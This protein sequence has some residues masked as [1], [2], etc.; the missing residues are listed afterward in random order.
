MSLHNRRCNAL[1]P[2]PIQTYGPSF[3][4]IGLPT[5]V[6]SLHVLE[7]NH[8]EEDEQLVQVSSNV[9]VANLLQSETLMY[10]RHT[11]LAHT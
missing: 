4:I 9:N 3:N 7:Q 11:V 10:S 2:S 8:L 5:F 1:A 6:Q